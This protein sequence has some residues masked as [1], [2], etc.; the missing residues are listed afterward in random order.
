MAGRRE[1]EGRTLL[2]RAKKRFPDHS[3]ESLRV[4]LS[5]PL[6]ALHSKGLAQ[7]AA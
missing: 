4:F 5:E 7:L 2:E 3:V 6:Y 1:E